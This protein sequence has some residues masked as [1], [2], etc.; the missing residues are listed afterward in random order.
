[1]SRYWRLL[2]LT[3]LLFGC[4]KEEEDVPDDVIAPEVVECVP[5]NGAKAVS[6]ETSLFI[7]YSEEIKLGKAYNITL[8]NQHVETWRRTQI[9]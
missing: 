7:T 2:C 1:M 8:N 5:E 4:G 9:T 3:V 6:L